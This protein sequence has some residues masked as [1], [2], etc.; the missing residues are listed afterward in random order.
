MRHPVAHRVALHATDDAQV[1]LPVDSQVEQGV[2][3]GVGGKGE[4]QL[5]A[6]DGD[7]QGIDAVPVDHRRHL[8]LGPQPPRRPGTLLATYL[9]T[10]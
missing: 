6:L 2:H 7:G 3:P 8:P 5:A 10:E 1:L 9:C 4:A